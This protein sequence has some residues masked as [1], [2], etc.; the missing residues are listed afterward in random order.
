VLSSVVALIHRRRSGVVLES[1]DGHLLLDPTIPSTT[2]MSILAVSRFP[3]CSMCSSKYPRYRPSKPLD[4]VELRYVPAEKG[5]ALLDRLTAARYVLQ[6]ARQSCPLGATSVQA[7]L[8]IL[9]DDDLERMTRRHA[10][11]GE[12]LCDLD[13]G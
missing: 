4:L 8:F 7:A 10:V 13:R 1:G 6:L 2:P 12:R 5:D 3:P 9:P 11:L